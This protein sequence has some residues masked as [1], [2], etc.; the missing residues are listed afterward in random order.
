MQYH[1]A[2]P[3]QSQSMLGPQD[4]NATLDE[5]NDFGD[6]DEALAEAIGMN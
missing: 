5:I 2:V 1:P 3:S 6:K 4:L